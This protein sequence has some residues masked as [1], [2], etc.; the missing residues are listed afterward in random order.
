MNRSVRVYIEGGATG[1][2]AD[3]DFRYGWKRLLN[4]PHILARENGYHSLEVVRRKDR[5]RTFDRFTKYKKQFPNDLCVLLV[6]A[7]T[8]VPSG[9]RMWDIVANRKGDGWRRPPWATESHLY[10]M[11]HFVETWLLTDQNALQQFFKK[12][13][14]LR[15]LPT[16]NLEGRPKHEIETALKRA[17]Q[18]SSKGC[19]QIAKHT[20]LLGV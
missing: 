6:D 1:R 13:L 5:A 18:R 2:T 19:Y 14:D 8:A 15:V 12:G 3:R 4:E 10:L 17:T 16:T 20:K 7:E 11:V 9:S